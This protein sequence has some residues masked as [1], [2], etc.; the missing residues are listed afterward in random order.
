ML[1]HQT[2]TNP[3]GFHRRQNSTPNLHTFNQAV[4]LP[5]TTHHDELHLKSHGT[6]LGSP[7]RVKQESEEDNFVKNGNERQHIQQHLQETQLPRARP[8]RLEVNTQYQ[9]RPCRGPERVQCAIGEDGLLSPEDIDALLMD[10]EPSGIQ[11]QEQHAD[12]SP[13]FVRDH[14]SSKRS[15]DTLAALNGANHMT[16]SNVSE[17]SQPSLQPMQSLRQSTD[18]HVLP[19]PCTPEGQFIPG[20]SP[21]TFWCTLF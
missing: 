4:L 1:S 3:A 5:K 10:I 9:Y 13:L 12:I 19:R 8:G 2:C 21:A 20:K 7:S 16:P 15:N 18:S 6:R 14:D 11:T 17:P